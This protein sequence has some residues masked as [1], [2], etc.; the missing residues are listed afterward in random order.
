MKLFITLCLS[1]LCLISLSQ[2]EQNEQKRQEIKK[3][4]TELGYYKW[5]EIQQTYI[6]QSQELLTLKTAYIKAKRK[7]V[8]TEDRQ[9][10]LVKLRGQQIQKLALQD[11]A[12]AEKLAKESLKEKKEFEAVVD[13]LFMKEARL[14]TAKQRCEKLV[15]GLE[16]LE[17]KYSKK[18]LVNEAKINDLVAELKTLTPTEK[19]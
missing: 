15:K 19:K 17:S 11:P 13:K 4:L 5:M 12:K 16:I 8:D 3:Q 14:L 6:A 9:Q 10:E 18:M 2:A 7:R 1:F